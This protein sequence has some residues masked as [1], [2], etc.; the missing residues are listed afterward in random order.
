MSGDASL[1]AARRS[2]E[3]EQ[4]A[5]GEVVDVLVVGGGVTGAGVALDAAARG[6]SVALVE[7]RDLAHGTS[8]WSSKLVHGGLRYLAGGHLAVAY[9]SAVER[10]ILMERTAPHLTRPLAMV[11]PL[12]VAYGR[13]AA[14]IVGAGFVAGNLLRV[15][16]GTR[17]STLPGPRWITAQET[18]LLL[19]AVR[20][21][22]LRG[23]LLSWDGQLVDDARLVVAIARTAAA[24]GARI[25]TYAPAEQVSGTAALVRDE[26]GG[27]SLEIRARAVVNAT[28]VWA[29][30][31]DPSVTLRPSK[32]AHLLLDASTL[33]DPRAALAVPVPGQRNRFVFA[34]PQADGRVLLGLT[35]DPADEVVDVPLADEADETFLLTV[36]SEALEVPLTSRDVIGSFAGLRPLLAAAGGSTADLS[37]HHRISR[38]P[39]GLVT[40]VG[41]KLTTYRQMA[42][43]TV[44]L[45]VAGGLHA[46]SSPTRRLPLVGAA[47]RPELARVAAP[48]ELVARYGTE[49][50]ALAGRM[51]DEPELADAIVPGGVNRM[52]EAVWAVQHEGALLAEDVVDRRTRIGLVP[53]QRAGALARVE[54]LLAASRRG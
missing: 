5:A 6:L 51:R 13:R 34:V 18:A 29:G 27:G 15:A 10:G 3:L 46:G 43:Q 11:A 36:V 23:G 33:G 2:R 21:A 19:P 1:N 44:D 49:A 25:L 14:Q 7:R 38:T 42:E 30:Q 20:R 35:D 12:G 32:G 47:P 37:R 4:L 16:A 50:P 45:V 39:D 52:V 40:V 24:H 31:L 41:G 26:I 48:A 28:G 53:A 9:A 54:P 17:R 8:R 22:G